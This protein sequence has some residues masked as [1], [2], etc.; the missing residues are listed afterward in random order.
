LMWHDR[1]HAH[2]VNAAGAHPHTQTAASKH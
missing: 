1:L 2:P